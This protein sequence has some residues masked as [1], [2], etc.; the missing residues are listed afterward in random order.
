MIDSAGSATSR[1]L[2]SKRRLC[3]LGKQLEAIQRETASNT[4]KIAALEREE[5]KAITSTSLFPFSTFFKKKKI[6]T[7][8][9]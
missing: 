7:N 6:Y 8:K 2:A 4:S 9:L 1:L 3:D 5:H